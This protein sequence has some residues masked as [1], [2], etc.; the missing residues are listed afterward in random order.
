[1]ASASTNDG[2]IS[3][4]PEQLEGMLTKIHMRPK[5]IS[6][7]YDL[8]NVNGTKIDKK[9]IL[10]AD[11]YKR[12]INDS[13]RIENAMHLAE[14]LKVMKEVHNDMQSGQLD[15]AVG[16]IMRDIKGDWGHIEL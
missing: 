6:P 1:M 15:D 14:A 5:I 13:E 10:F 2:M 3:L 4:T 12:K 11:L 16:E 8:V 7:Y 9:V